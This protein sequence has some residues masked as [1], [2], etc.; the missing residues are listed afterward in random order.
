MRAMVLHKPA[1]IDSSPLRAEDVPEPAP[2]DRDIVVRVEAC[3]VC[4]TDLH[5]VEGDLPPLRPRIIPGH[6]VVGI[7]ERRGPI[8][9]R[10]NVG[11]RVG[12]AW[13]RHTCGQCAYCREG[14]ENLCPSA[15]FT[16]YHEDGGYAQRACIDEDFAYPLP[17]GRDAAAMTPLLCA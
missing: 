17:R 14:K 13:L 2:G 16:G 10:F 9:T 12:I 4:R 8:A 11:D 6:Q 1:P 15:R 7:V 5:V 3:G